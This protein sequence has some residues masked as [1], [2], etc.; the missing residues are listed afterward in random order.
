VKETTSFNWIMKFGV[1]K[2]SPGFFIGLR[3]N[4]NSGN[5]NTDLVKTFCRFQS[6]QQ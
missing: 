2:N 6:L 5:V 3:L 1:P 4:K